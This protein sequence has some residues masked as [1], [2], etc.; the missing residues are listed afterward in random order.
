MPTIKE[1]QAQ[2]KE[3][4]MITNTK[5]GKVVLPQK[6]E[7]YGLI[8]I[9]RDPVRKLDKMSVPNQTS[10]TAASNY[11]GDRYYRE[12][13]PDRCKCEMVSEKHNVELR[14]HGKDFDKTLER[15]VKVLVKLDKLDTLAKYP[16]SY[17]KLRRIYGLVDAHYPWTYYIQLFR[18]SHEKA[19]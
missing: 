5:E 16:A 15:A 2:L 8:R 18:N 9:E 3:S 19:S 4:I 17:P 1:T 14:F 10:Y 13:Q 6:I 7:G 12:T 11:Y